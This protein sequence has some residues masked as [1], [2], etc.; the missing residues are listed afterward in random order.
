MARVHREISAS[1]TIKNWW[2]GIWQPDI[3]TDQKTNEKV[4]F[5]EV[6]FETLRD[7][8][9]AWVLHPGENWHGFKDL[10]ENYCMLDPIK[11]TVTMPGVNENGTLDPWGIPAAVVVKFLET[12]GIVNE[13]S[14]DY[15]ILFLFSMGNTKGKWGTLIT[16]LFEFKRHYD[17]KTP[18]EEVFPD[19]IHA[20]PE[21]YSGMTLQ[22][23][24]DEMHTFKNEHNMCC[25]LQEA[26]SILPEP[27]LTYAD[28][29]Q[30]IVRG[31]V[32]QIPITQAG[33]RIAATGIYPYP[34]G[35]PLFAPGE[36]T[37]RQDGPLLQYLIAL[38]EFDTHY[39]GFEHDIHG[40]ELMKGGYMMYCVKEE[41][42]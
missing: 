2:F 39:P 5:E 20:Y 23:L 38:Q 24:T 22:S 9:S 15:T 1:D 18:L 30:K 32:E 29:Y 17:E 33:S 37:G 4:N 40:V 42:K 8:P 13:K 10:P 21:R 3:V 36:R 6:P 28:A 16:E 14:G 12:R 27:A 7:D 34:P 19:L 35:I 31:E 41:Q 25:L 11:V 26:F